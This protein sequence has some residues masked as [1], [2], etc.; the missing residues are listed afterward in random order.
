MRREER[1]LVNHHTKRDEE[2][3]V[4]C[5]DMLQCTTGNDIGDKDDDNIDDDNGLEAV[6]K[7]AIDQQQC[8]GKLRGLI[9]DD[10]NTV[11]RNGALTRATDL[12]LPQ[13]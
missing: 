9:S 8:E 2:D 5:V 4:N 13:E 7:N 10:A 3:S 1:V 6:T 11:R 12:N